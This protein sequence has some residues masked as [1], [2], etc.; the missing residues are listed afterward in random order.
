MKKNT[1]NFFQLDFKKI[2]RQ[3]GNGKLIK[4]VNILQLVLVEQLQVVVLIY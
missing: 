4:A 1:K 2:V 3:Q